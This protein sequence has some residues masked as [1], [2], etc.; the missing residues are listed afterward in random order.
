MTDLSRVIMKHTDEARLAF[1]LLTLLVHE[2][3]IRDTAEGIL[4]GGQTWAN[5]VALLLLENVT[6]SSFFDWWSLHH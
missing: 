5:L 1:V 6:T 2:M 3:G 4:T